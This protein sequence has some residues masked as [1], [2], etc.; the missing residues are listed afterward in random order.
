M[1]NKFRDKAN[2]LERGKKLFSRLEKR[3]KLIEF[4]VGRLRVLTWTK[5]NEAKLS[6][7]D[8]KQKRETQKR[9]NPAATKDTTERTHTIIFNFMIN[10]VNVHFD[11]IVYI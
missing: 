4:V 3:T 5:G 1:G 9:S 11:I 6:T 8:W 2:F 7:A 10:N